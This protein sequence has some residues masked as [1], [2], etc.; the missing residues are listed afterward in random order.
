[1]CEAYISAGMDPARFWDITPRLLEIEFKG[2]K[3]R[4]RREREMVWY[5]AAMARSEK[6]PSL[7]KFLGDPVDDRQRV[8]AVNLAFDKLDRSLARH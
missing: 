3:G 4:L 1:M 7:E 2:V 6:M 5:G 8:E